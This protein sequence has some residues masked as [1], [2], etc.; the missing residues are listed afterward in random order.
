MK[1]KQNLA[2]A[3]VY[4]S[5]YLGGAPF[6]LVGGF[7][8]LKC[9]DESMKTALRT[10][11]KLFIVFICVNSLAVILNGVFS[12]VWLSHALSIVTIVVEILKVVVFGLLAY[13]AYA[14]NP[15]E[16]CELINHSAEN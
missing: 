2:A 8:F 1:I 9:K 3:L 10:A 15:K 11:L 16:S 7:F 4:I 13:I 12:I 6:T 5:A 14:K